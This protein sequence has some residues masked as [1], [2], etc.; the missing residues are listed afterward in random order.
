MTKILEQKENGDLSFMKTQ[1]MVTAA[2]SAVELSALVAG[3]V[4]VGD[5]VQLTHNGL[6]SVCCV[7]LP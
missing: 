6:C 4:S 7:S 5:K 2:T 1:S 3:V